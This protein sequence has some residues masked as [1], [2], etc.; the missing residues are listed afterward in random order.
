M[1]PLP[2]HS[3]ELVLRYISPLSDPLPPH[4][5]STPLRQRHHFLQI[6]TSSPVEYLCWPSPDNAKIIDLLDRLPPLSDHASY[7]TRYTSDPESSFAHGLRMLFHWDD[8]HGWKYHDL[9]LM[10]FPSLSFSNPEESLA[11]RSA[12]RAGSPRPSWSVG[13]IAEA[14]H[15]NSGDDDS[16]WDAYGTA[17]CD[18]TSPLP[19]Q[20]SSDVVEGEDAYWAQYASVQGSADSTVPSPLPTHRKLR[21]MNPESAFPFPPQDDSIVDIP[22]DAIHSRP[23]PSRIEPPSPNML[24]HLLSSISPRKEISSVLD[25]PY[26]LRSPSAYNTDPSADETSTATDSELVTPPLPNGCLDASFVS[27]VA[28]KLN[29]VPL[30]KSRSRP[31]QAEDM[32]LTDSIKGLY[33]LWK[34]A[35]KGEPDETE[36]SVFLEIVRAAIAHE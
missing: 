30:L 19:P 33:Y 15:I 21:L 24:A 18:L 26:S 14:D 9:R 31:D 25:D 6:S 3:V 27:P 12:R 22:V 10:P 23:L 28:V 4:L 13:L 17:G 36:R 35:K 11:S 34:A 5:V 20:N 29:G 16:Y 2:A 1:F 7:P 32:A 8:I